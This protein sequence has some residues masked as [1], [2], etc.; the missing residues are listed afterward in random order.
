MEKLAVVGSGGREHAIA[1][2]LRRSLENGQVIS[3]P[4][5]PGM[6][7]VGEC[8]AVDLSNPA[9][10]AAVAQ[11]EGVDLAVIGPEVPL[12]AGA[13]DE[14]E[15][16]DILAFG[17]SHEAA[18]LE[19]SK[20]FMKE[21]A[22]AAGVPTAEYRSFVQGDSGQAMTYYNEV[23][24]GRRQAVIKADG[25]AAG[26]G[27]CLPKNRREAF[28]FITG[29]LSGKLF[30]WAGHRVVIEE[31]L[32]GREVSLMA[33]CDGRQAVPLDPARDY[34]RLLDNDE[35]PNTGGMGSFS[36]VP[37]VPPELAGEL[38]QIGVE[39]I[40]HHM[41]AQGNPYRGIM[42]AGFMLTED[43]PQL[44]EINARF[45]DP[46]AQVVLPRLTSSLADHCRESAEGKLRTPVEFSDEAAVTVALT[47]AGY[48]ENPQT[49]DPIEGLT[50]AQ[51]VEGASVF[52]GATR[53][54]DGRVVTDGGRVLY[55]TGLGPDLPKARTRAYQAADKISWPGLHRR[56][57]IGKG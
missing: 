11:R 2:Q 57:E 30:G 25:L 12:V 48:P 3:L 51:N 43:G 19:G 24:R 45:G 1:M 17:P 33:L 10:I 26:K 44:L 6:A 9:E 39:P 27:V 16:H 5:N 14:L 7:E 54:V 50:A 36:P 53:I 29:C 49:G 21:I 46:E 38:M 22:T 42:Y 8:F 37:D 23:S 55:A 4:G 40:L 47:A 20:T 56:E 34:K 41:K 18:W 35:G 28:E 52:H 15:R 13:V 31:R 32:H